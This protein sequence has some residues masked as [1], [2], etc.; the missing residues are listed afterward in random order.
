MIIQDHVKRIQFAVS[1][2]GEADVF[3]G[4]EWLKKH[5]PDVDWRASSLFFTWCPDECNY[6]TWFSD[7]DTDTEEN[8][9]HVHLME[10]EKLY[11]FNIEGYML[12]RGTF[13]G[14]SQEDTFE[15]KV[16]SH[17]HNYKDVFDKKD[18]DQL[19]E[20]RVWDHAI[21]LNENFKPVDCKVYPLNP[22]EQKVLEDFIEEN[23]SSGRIR[24]SKSPMASP[25]F[26][27]KKPDGKLHSTQDY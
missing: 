3:I 1:D 5:N 20:R 16:L 12:N 19:P 21:E 2:L 26:F 4:Y 18:F 9:H 22:S 13:M 10:G 27:V 25:F 23:L 14:D 6:I 7:I 8:L 24:P 11:A 15:Q 17:Y